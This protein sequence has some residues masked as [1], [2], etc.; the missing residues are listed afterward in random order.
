MTD[1]TYSTLYLPSGAQEEAAQHQWDLWKLYDV[2][3]HIHNTLQYPN[4]V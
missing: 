4:T 3:D 2:P 1:H